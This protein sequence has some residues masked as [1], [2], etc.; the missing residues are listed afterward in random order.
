MA[1][2]VPG[3]QEAFKK[4]QLPFVLLL[5][6]FWPCHVACGILAPQSGTESVVPA[7]GAQSLN[8]WITMDIPGCLSFNPR[9]L[10]NQGQGRAATCSLTL[11]P[12]VVI[13]A[14][15]ALVSAVGNAHCGPDPAPSTSQII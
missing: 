7:L 2:F 14:L 5:L 12:R 10:R 8:H 9:L 6:F 3:A 11:H 4:H 13:R 15:Q 1:D